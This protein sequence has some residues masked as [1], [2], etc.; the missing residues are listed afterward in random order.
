MAWVEAKIKL[1]KSVVDGM[2]N[3]DVVSCPMPE[4]GMEGISE[5]SIDGKS[6]GIGAWEIDL[7]DDILTIVLAMAGSKQKEKSDDKPVEGRDTA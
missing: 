4:D 7:R 2:V 3:D 5:I 1:G 6:Y